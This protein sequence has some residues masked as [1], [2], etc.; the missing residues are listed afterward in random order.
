MGRV[1]FDALVIIIAA[2]AIGLAINLCNPRGFEPVPRRSLAYRKILPITVVEAKLKYDA[3]IARFIDAR[4]THEY[5][6]TR[7]AGAVSIPALDGP[8][9]G[10]G[11]DTS[12]LGAPAEIVIYCD[13]PD[14]G[15]SDILARRVIDAGYS[16]SVYILD[17]GLPEWEARGFPV[18]RGE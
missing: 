14:C 13:G 4:E 2:A 1:L 3:N 17:K 11:R 9:P 18:E 5:D 6:T 16:R 10:K 7:I 15:A 12:V 8:L